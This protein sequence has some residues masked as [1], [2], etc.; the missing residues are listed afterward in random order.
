MSLRSD[1]GIGDAYG[2]S[3]ANAVA[4]GI[5]A[6]TMVPTATKT[7][8][9]TASVSDLV[10]ADATSAA[11][12]VTL[13]TTPAPG[14]RVIVK[15]IDSSTNAVTVA[16]GGNDVF[17]AS[18]GSTSLSL[19][20]QYQAVTLHY[21]LGVW[22]VIAD[23]LPLARLDARYIGV[24]GSLA[25]ATGLPISG[26]TSSTTTAL[27]VGS[28]ELGAA[29]DTTL[30]RSAAGVLAVEGVVIPSI[31]STSTLTNKRITARVGTTTSSATPAINVDSYDLFTITALAAAITS[32]TSGLSGTPT[33]GQM[34]A[35]RFKDNGTAR[36]ITWGTSFASTGTGTLLATTVVSKTHLVRL[37]YDATAAKW[38]CLSSDSTGY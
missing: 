38:A 4:A 18:G 14:S 9:Y 13:P 32:L 11:F 34:L 6:I 37:M 1:W 28:I 17:N 22:I 35:I 20:L 24:A 25:T 21:S 30:S 16:R 3:D 29:S 5:N 27:G 15:K 8:A 19:S 10:L 33:D 36:A 31:S 23:D 26:L 7:A 2:P 12:T